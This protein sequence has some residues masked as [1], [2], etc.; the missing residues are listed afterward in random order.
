MAS[1]DS[2]VNGSERL[3]EKMICYYCV[4]TDS[5]IGSHHEVTVYRLICKDTIEEKI[6]Q[7]AKQKNA[8]QELVMKGKQV[9]DD[10]LMRQED[11]VSLLLDDTQIAH[12]LKEISMQA[13]DRLKKRRAKAIKVD[14]EGDLKL[15]DLDDPTEE[16]VEQDNTTSKKQQGGV[17]PPQPCAASSSHFF[18]CDRINHTLGW[19]FEKKSSHKKPPKSQ[20]NDGADG[21]VPESGPVKNEEHIASLRPKR[22]KRLVRSTGEDKEPVAACD[23][24]KP[25]DAAENNDNNDAEE[26]QD[27]TPSA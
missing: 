21:D 10:H 7:R 22:S 8:V 20:D 15:E 2:F 13:K 18:L 19:G 26:L 23:V 17:A 5:S 1:K 14:K 24:E 4:V 27:Q 11:V 6:L 9:Q 12:K 25:A 16:P 3:P